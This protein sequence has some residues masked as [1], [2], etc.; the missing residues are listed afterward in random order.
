ML[1][2]QAGTVVWRL[3]QRKMPRTNRSL[4]MELFANELAP[5]RR[6]MSEA[7]Q[8]L[9]LPPEALALIKAGTSAKVARRLSQ[10][11]AIDPRHLGHLSRR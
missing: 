4:F 8:T 10:H 5:Q 7:L 11:H 3:G 6:S 9:E 2:R 1:M